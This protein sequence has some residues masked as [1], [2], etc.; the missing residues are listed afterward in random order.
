MKQLTTRHLLQDLHRGYL[1]KGQHG[2][3]VHAGHETNRELHDKA[4]AAGKTNIVLT[5]RTGDQA[6]VMLVQP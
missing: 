2:H 4:T 3:D 1:A 5:R 6:G